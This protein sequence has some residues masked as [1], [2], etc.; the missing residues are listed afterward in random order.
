MPG[1][2]PSG[3]FTYGTGG[4]LAGCGGTGEAAGACADATRARDKETIKAKR[5]AEIRAVME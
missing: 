1:M 3:A 4:L 2:S 5:Q